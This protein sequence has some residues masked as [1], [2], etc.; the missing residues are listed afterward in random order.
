MRR[1]T[2]MASR[3]LAIAAPKW[4]T[5]LLR[6]TANLLIMG[7]PGSGKG[8]YGNLLANELNADLITAGDILRDE[9]SRGTNMGLA[10]KE[11]QAMGRLADDHLVSEAVRCY[12]VEKYGERNSS[13]SGETNEM[14][15]SQEKE[16]GGR[17]R[18]ILDG[19]PRTVAQAKII[20]SKLWPSHLRADVAVSID[21]PD[22]ICIDKV[23]K[24]FF[25]TMVSTCTCL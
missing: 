19:F 4:G 3:R 6:S 22:Q 10:I 5:P 12:L 21:V 17:V 14:Q 13:Q 1:A 20:Q 25:Q 16:S 9:V 18:F 15:A 24:C 7:P 8:T 2:T 23:R 11:C